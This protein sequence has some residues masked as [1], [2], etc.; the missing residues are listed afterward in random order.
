MILASLNLSLSLSLPLCLLFF[1]VLRIT[2]TFIGWTGRG[3]PKSTPVST[4]KRPEKTSVEP[5]STEP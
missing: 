2:P 1:Q 3:M 5:S 4:L